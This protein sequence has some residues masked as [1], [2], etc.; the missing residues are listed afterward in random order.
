MHKRVAIV[1]PWAIVQGWR[2]PTLQELASLVEPTVRFGPSLPANLFT[3]VRKSIYW[4]ATAAAGNPASAW[5]VNFD[6]GRVANPSETESHFVWCVRGGRAWMHNEWRLNCSK[7]TQ[8]KSGVLKRLDFSLSVI[9]C[10]AL[11]LG[12]ESLPATIFSYSASMTRC[13][14][15]RASS[16]AG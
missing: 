11:A 15:L 2:L 13:I 10:F 1:R 5:F 16:L 6:D 8:K 3:N 9:F 4:S 14:I 12:T 7:T